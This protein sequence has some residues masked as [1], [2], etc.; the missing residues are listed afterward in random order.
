VSKNSDDEERIGRVEDA[1]NTNSR[2]SD[3]KITDMRIAVVASNYDYP[4]IRIDTNQGVYG[5]GEVRDAG[6]KEN[7]LQFK[8]FLVGQNP[9]NVDMIFRAIKQFGNWGREGGG[10]SGIEIALW[11]L[12]GKVYDVPCYQF[13]GGKYR[14]KVRLYADTPAPEEPRPEGYAEVVRKRKTLGLTFIKFDIRPRL[15]EDCPGGVCGQPTR[16]EYEL[17][18]RWRAPGAGQ[19][20]KLTERGIARAVEVVAAVRAAAGWDV[21]LCTDH[22]GH[23]YLTAKEVI[24]L[25]K[26]LEPFGLAWLEDPMPWWDVDGHKQVT[27]A[28]EVPTAAGEELYL[29]DGFRE[30]IEKRAVDIIHPDLL[31]SGGMSE[32]KKIADYAE[33]HGLPTALHFAGSPIAFMANVHCAAAISSFVALEHHGLDLPFWKNLVTGLPDNYMED[34]YVA[35][36]DKPGLGVDLNYA[37]I[38][39]NLRSPGLFEPTDEWNTPKLGFWQPDRRWDK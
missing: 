19:G 34:G 17:G 30:L 35:V 33:R 39:A 37:G 7:A 38:E 31:T 8:N 4:I 9:C 15:F 26:A 5:I 10:V 23:G 29:W 22:F 18:R 2:P 32:T 6:H 25:G 27:D 3:L 36:P 28:I 21:S 13:L 14:D 12:V 11:D 20:M 1:V 16:F 24:R